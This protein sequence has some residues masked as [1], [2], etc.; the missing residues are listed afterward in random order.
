MTC[1]VMVKLSYPV[2]CVNGVDKAQNRC[3][4]PTSTVDLTQPETIHEHRTCKF[5]TSTRIYRNIIY[6]I[7][8]LVYHHCMLGV[9]DI[10]DNSNTS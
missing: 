5:T 2:T 6:E 3:E 1:A 7:H 10:L 4:P 9:F 8:L